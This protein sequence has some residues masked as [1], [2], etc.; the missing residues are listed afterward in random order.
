MSVPS[1]FLSGCC[2]CLHCPPSAYLDHAGH[3][4]T[5][6]VLRA[7]GLDEGV[8]V[9]LAEGEGEGEAQGAEAGPEEQQQQQQGRLR[10]EEEANEVERASTQGTGQVTPKAKPRGG[11]RQSGAA[12]EPVAGPPEQ[13]PQPQQQQQPPLGSAESPTNAELS[14]QVRI[15]TLPVPCGSVLL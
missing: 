12:V 3:E 1:R 15:P 5:A 13:Q 10:H 14:L 6:A 8:L 4:A 7:H 2:L 11:K 9:G